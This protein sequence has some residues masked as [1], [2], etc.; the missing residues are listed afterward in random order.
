MSAEFRALPVALF[1]GPTSRHIGSLLP[2]PRAIKDHGPIGGAVCEGASFRHNGSGTSTPAAGVGPDAASLLSLE[3]HPNILRSRMPV[4]TPVSARRRGKGFDGSVSFPINCNRTVHQ[5]VRIA[6]D[7]PARPSAHQEYRS[8]PLARWS[9]IPCRH[10]PCEL[11][12]SEM[13]RNRVALVAQRQKTAEIRGIQHNTL[14]HGML[15]NVSWRLHSVARSSTKFHE[16][17]RSSTTA[18]ASPACPSVPPER[19]P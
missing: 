13:P 1:T 15:Q 5:S 9:A 8:M 2:M 6:P 19:R 12:L 11:R 4:S 17:P 3:D 10:A 16:V 18:P 14:F 7:G